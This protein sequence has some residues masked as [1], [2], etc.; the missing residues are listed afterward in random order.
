MELG[1]FMQVNNN[2]TFNHCKSCLLKPC[3]TISS[4]CKA[5]KNDVNSLIKE[6]ELKQKEMLFSKDDHVENAYV[7]KRGVIKSF[8]ISE[9]GEAIILDFYYPGDIVAVDCLYNE[10]Y[11]NYAQATIESVICS[12]KKDIAT[13]KLETV[14]YLSQQLCHQKAMYRVL[15][16]LSVKEK[17]CYFLMNHSMKLSAGNCPLAHFSLGLTRADIANYLGLSSETIS[18]ALNE[19]KNNDI[20]SNSASHFTIINPEKLRRQCNTPPYKQTVNF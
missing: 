1:E 9:N 17:V 15:S 16:K 7:V 18:R 5:G 6:K 10:H 8:T 4:K 2:A 3:C 14:S 12:V 19:L 11:A 13:R 20:I